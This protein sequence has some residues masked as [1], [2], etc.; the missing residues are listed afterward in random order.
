MKK[1]IDG[2]VRYIEKRTDLMGYKQL[3]EEGLPIG[4]GM[5]EA[6]CKTLATERLKRSGM[7]WREPGVQAILT[8][9]SLLQSK[10]WE[11]AWQL[12]AAEYRTSILVKQAA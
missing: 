12:L 4:S 2:V 7:S 11:N 10:R 1:A 5:V 6:A 3:R 8:L 9:R